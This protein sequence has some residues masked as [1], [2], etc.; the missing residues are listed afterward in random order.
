MA[1]AALSSV[2]TSNLSR[3]GITRPG[4]PQRPVSYPRSHGG[5]ETKGRPA[6]PPRA[7]SASRPDPDAAPHW[8]STRA[9][10]C[11]WRC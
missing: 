10:L 9:R 11:H 3:A 5:M 6:V 7:P 2:S 8:T 4:T 1:F